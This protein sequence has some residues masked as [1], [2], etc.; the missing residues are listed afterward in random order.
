MAAVSL[1][2]GYVLYMK[3]LRRELRKGTLGDY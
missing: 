3:A 1:A 2:I